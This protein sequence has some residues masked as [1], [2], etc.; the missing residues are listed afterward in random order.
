MDAQVI[1]RPEAHG[2]RV[3]MFVPYFSAENLAILFGGSVHCSVQSGQLFV[4]FFLTFVRYNFSFDEFNSYCLYFSFII[5]HELGFE[6]RLERC[7][8]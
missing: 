2:H 6:M 7:C 8:I 1:S 3:L 4:L 5:F